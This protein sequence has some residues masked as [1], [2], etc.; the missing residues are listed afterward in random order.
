MDTDIETQLLNIYRYVKT[1]T[2]GIS[3]VITRHYLISLSDIITLITNFSCSSINVLKFNWL[4]YLNVLYHMIP[5]N[6]T[7][8]IISRE[9]YCI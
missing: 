6:I 5:Y 3:M 8:F 1:D 7:S 9:T 2:N 4:T